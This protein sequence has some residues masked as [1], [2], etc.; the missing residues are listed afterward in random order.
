MKVCTSPFSIC[1]CLCG[2]ADCLSDPTDD[3]LD[4]YHVNW[5]ARDV[6][7]DSHISLI[8]RWRDTCN[9]EHTACGLNNQQTLP[10]RV[11]RLQA[12]ARD[13]PPA[14][15]LAETGGTLKGKYACL[16]YCWGTNEAGRTTKDTFAQYQAQIPLADLPNTVI[17]AV[18]LCIKLGYQYLW[19][20]RL[21]IIQ[22]DYTDWIQEAGRMCDI[23]SRSDLTISTAICSD[24]SESFRI[25]RQA[26][27]PTLAGVPTTIVWDDYQPKILIV[28]AVDD[29]WRND[30]GL[31]DRSHGM[32]S[33]F[34]EEGWETFSYHKSPDNDK[35]ITRAWTFQEWL[36][37]PRV[38]HI[39]E[40]TVWDCF[41]AYGNE[42]NRR[43]L[44]R[45]EVKLTRDPAVPLSWQEIVREY[46]QRQYTQ[47][48][49]RLPALAGLAARYGRERAKGAESD[50]SSTYVGGLWLED[51]PLDLLW[52]KRKH[53]DEPPARRSDQFRAPSWSWAS[54]SHPVDFEI[55]RETTAVTT[56]VSYQG[57]SPQSSSTGDYMWLD[58]EGPLC[59]IWTSGYTGYLDA[60]LQVPMASDGCPFY[61][62]EDVPEDGVLVWLLRLVIFHYGGFSWAKGLVLK[63]IQT[64]NTQSAVAQQ[65][66][67]SLR[68]FQRLGMVMESSY[69]RN[70]LITPSWPQPEQVARIRLV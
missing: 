33:W 58:V 63:E 66:P 65:V 67:N 10:T 14:V 42:I 17:D 34:L 40:M 59:A 18:G 27:V 36:L 15:R 8:R 51:L 60:D 69:S 53:M 48:K 12:G 45:G 56:V 61:W 28:D 68:C 4:P 41:E 39:H 19:V 35:W 52:S 31:K 3:S 26:T 20:D 57:S 2:C 50:K 32:G 37:S 9:S 54:L 23:Y 44:N 62:D 64:H 30:R 55:R 24:A 38:L 21:C 43:R 13:Q 16:S 49:D 25:K 46:S 22:D 70:N 1:S 11:L 6:F 5:P 47:A 7:S 29:G